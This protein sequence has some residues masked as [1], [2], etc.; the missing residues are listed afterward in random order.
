[1]T[2]PYKPNRGVSLQNWVD[3]DCEPARRP[4][5]TV[6]AR[7]YD[8]IGDDDQPTQVFSLARGH[9]HSNWPALF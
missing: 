5:P 6:V 1:M 3:G 4:E 2:A 8:T 9:C 7:D